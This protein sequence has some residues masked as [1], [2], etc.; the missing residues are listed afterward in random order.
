MSQKIES[1]GQSSRNEA[2]SRDMPKPIPSAQ[3]NHP[4]R[5]SIGGLD[6]S[7]CTIN[8]FCRSICDTHELVGSDQESSR[9]IGYQR[10]IGCRSLGQVHRS[11]TCFAALINAPEGGDQE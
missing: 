9:C 2:R 4:V 5:V 7:G 8:Y 10:N 1:R 6:M 11:E 3:P